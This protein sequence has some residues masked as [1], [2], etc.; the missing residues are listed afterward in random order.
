MTVF[1]TKTTVSVPKR[2]LAWAIITKSTRKQRE[3]ERREKPFVTYGG[4]SGSQ[5]DADTVSF[6]VVHK[7]LSTPQGF[8][9]Y[10]SH[11]PRTTKSEFSI[12]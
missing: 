5:V 4:K 2:C 3:R 11:V 1:D 8:E 12:F 10:F 9:K 7:T 6:F